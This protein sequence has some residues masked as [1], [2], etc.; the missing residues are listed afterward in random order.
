[1]R[2]DER[3]DRR[4]VR[5]EEAIY[6]LSAVSGDRSIKPKSKFKTVSSSLQLPRMRYKAGHNLSGLNER[7]NKPQ[8]CTCAVIKILE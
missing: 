7:E 4:M 1:M 8:H 5:Y 2:T 6:T 3:K